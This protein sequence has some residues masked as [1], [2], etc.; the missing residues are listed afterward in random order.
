MVSERPSVKVKFNLSLIESILMFQAI[1]KDHS[2]EISI[3][4]YKLFFRCLG[5][6]EEA[7]AIS[8]AVID[9]NGDGKLSMKE[10]VKLGRD[11]FLN[12]DESCASK[13]FWGPLVDH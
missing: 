9:R 12:E 11:F 1:D 5:L 3:E 13:M 6:T 7:A 10:F 4:E 2:G 8:F